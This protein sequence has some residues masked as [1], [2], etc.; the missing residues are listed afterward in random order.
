MTLLL[1]PHEILPNASSPTIA[2]AAETRATKQALASVLGA[3]FI[4]AASVFLF[5]ALGHVPLL[6]ITAQRIAWSLVAVA[7]WLTV[8]GGWPQVRAALTNPRSL[9]TLMLSSIFAALNWL[10]FVWAISQ[11]RIVE[12]SFGYFVAPIVIVA[13]GA[14]MLRERLNGAQKLAVALV[15]AAA[16][17]QGA[18]LG[19]FPWFSLAIGLNWALYTYVRKRVPVPAVA[20]FFIECLILSGPALLFIAFLEARGQSHF[21]ADRATTLLLLAT[22]VTTA[23]PLIL[24]AAANNKLRMVTMGLMQYVAPSLQLGMAAFLYAEPVSPI[25]LATFIVIWLALGIFSW[26]AARWERGVG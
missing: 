2:P 16:L 6:E 9:R 21:F 22:S 1:P 12:T 7:L 23:L 10:L 24:F 5:K 25:K 11:A 4:W 13:L 8:S 18:T 26:D 20:G 3:N 14:V 17:I 19:S 15:I